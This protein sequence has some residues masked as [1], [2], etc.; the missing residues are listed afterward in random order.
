MMVCGALAGLGGAVR[1]LSWF[2]LFA[3]EYFR[4][5][6]VFGL[7]GGDVGWLPA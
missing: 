7:I 6:W 1:V 5:H 4:R 2:G 3:P